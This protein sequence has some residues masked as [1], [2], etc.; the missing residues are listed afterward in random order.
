MILMRRWSG[1]FA[2]PIVLILG[3]A[4]L[5]APNLR[6]QTAEPNRQE[7]RLHI[8][9]AQKA[10]QAGRFAEA[11]EEFRTIV[12]MDPGNLDARGNLGV[13]LFFQSR[14][15]EA[16]GQFRRVLQE[17][18]QIWKVQALLGMCDRR[19]GQAAE[20]KQLLEEALPHLEEAGLKTEAG[21]ELIEML[22]QDRDLD[23]AVDVIRILQRC[24][25]DN[26]DVLYTAAR[27]YADL[28]NDA[29]DFL[30]Q[31]SPD[32]ART[33]RFM[34]QYLVNAGEL[35]GAIAQYRK[36]LEID[37]NI[38]GVHLEL[39]QAILRDSR[40]EAAMEASRTEL[41]AALKEN[42]DDPKAEFWLGQ[43]ETVSGNFQA[44]IRHYSR[45]VQLQAGY[46]DAHL[47]LGVS[48]MELNQP[49]KA[50]ED[51]LAAVR[52]DSSNSKSHYRLAEAYRELGRQADA[53]QEIATFKKLRDQ[54]KRLQEVYQQMHRAA[55]H[56]DF[57]EP[58]VPRTESVH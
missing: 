41:Q 54:E 4:P 58:A 32:S 3:L 2:N 21:L 14:W 22:Y 50:L 37:R 11:G 55:P 25:P 31:T 44:A 5:C 53:A 56:Q 47:C 20:A 52:L 35:Q 38:R 7:I 8:E 45:A 6:C 46:A 36:A 13:V 49:E 29:R 16:A 10:M 27:I 17:R 40:S 39:A 1:W 18:P 19:L 42:P 57:M 33:H 28:A 43:L 23:R 48:W 12:S 51:L 9:R 24:S 26:V 15:S 30:I 34:A